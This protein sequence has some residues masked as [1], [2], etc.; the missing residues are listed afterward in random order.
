MQRRISKRADIACKTVPGFLR[1]MEDLRKGMLI[2]GLTQSTFINYSRKLA[3]L[4]LHF[5]KLPED[6]TEEEL[7]DYLAYLIER[8]K[9]TSLSEF[10][11]TV[12]GI[13]YY[14]KIYGRTTHVSLP[15]LKFELRLPV[16]L[17]KQECKDMF[18][19][20]KNFKHRLVLQFLYSAGLRLSELVNLKWNQIDYDRMTVLIK[21]AKGKKDRLVPLSTHI[22]DGLTAY[23]I[24]GHKGQYVF[25]GGGENQR[26]SYSSVRFMMRCAIKRAGIKKDGVCL[27]TLRHS[28]ATHLLEEGLDIF[29]IKEL[30]GH[31]RIQSTMIYLHVVDQVK[32]PK[33]SPLDTLLGK[34][35]E[36][37]VELMRLKY[38]SL[39]IER[40]SEES[41]IPDQLQLFDK[42]CEVVK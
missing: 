26:M 37:E 23:L 21:Q 30:L 41:M 1:L 25:N 27:H 3:D 35:G 14:F 42:E 16:V 13:R 32:Y 2:T 6:L 31:S 10:K 34:K 18:E 4:S 19:G 9:S 8:A 29:S 39:F 7:R 17:S 33:F 24:N 20:T 15:K 12:Y 11:Q 22:L 28:F 5:K 38:K 36:T 40:N